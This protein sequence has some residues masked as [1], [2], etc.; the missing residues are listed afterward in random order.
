MEQ[1]F[2]GSKTIITTSNGEK[3]EF[4]SSLGQTGGIVNNVHDLLV[5]NGPD[6]FTINTRTDDVKL[7]EIVIRQ[8][9]KEEQRRVLEEQQRDL[10]ARQIIK[11]T[12]RKI[13]RF[14]K[15]IN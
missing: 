10:E 2:V 6:D 1:P 11:N 4:V 9:E 12:Q 5:F 14:Q 8:R 13:Q 15:E 7:M 3:I